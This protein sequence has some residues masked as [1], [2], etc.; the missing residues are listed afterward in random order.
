MPRSRVHYA[1]I[2]L[3][4][5]FITL[6]AAAAIRSIPGIILNSLEQEFAWP[7]ESITLA[8]SINLLLFGLAGPFLGRLMDYYGPR[9]FGGAF[10]A[11]R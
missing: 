1:W 10:A 7:R 11:K 5:A 4:V 6:I 9:I 2:V 3:A 8:V